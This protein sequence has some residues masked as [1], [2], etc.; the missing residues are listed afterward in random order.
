MTEYTVSG[1]GMK[2]GV[3][4]ITSGNVNLAHET[5]VKVVGSDK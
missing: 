1:E 5:P 3:Q 2:E 4:V